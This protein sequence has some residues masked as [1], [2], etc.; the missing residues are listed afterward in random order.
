MEAVLQGE[1]ERIQGKSGTAVFDLVLLVFAGGRGGE[2]EIAGD[3]VEP[4]GV[5]APSFS[6][7]SVAKFSRFSV[8]RTASSQWPSLHS[9]NV[10]NT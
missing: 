9:R 8:A 5:G 4:V 6:R 2:G 7:F 10:R 1:A 3:G